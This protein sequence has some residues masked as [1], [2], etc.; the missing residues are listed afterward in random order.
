[1]GGRAWAWACH[2]L[3]GKARHA[4]LGG[5][6][7]AGLNT[8]LSAYSTGRCWAHALELL[9]RWPLE[10]A[11]ANVRSFGAA[12]AAC[13]QGGQWPWALELL[14]STRF[15]RVLP[16][17]FTFSSAMDACGKG[18]RWA[19]AQWL[20]QEMRLSCS[21]QADTIVFGAA[22]GACAAQQS[23][24]HRGLAL[25]QAAGRLGLE[26]SVVSW[27]AAV[28]ACEKDACWQQ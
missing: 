19:W 4:G 14:H 22:I 9:C 25:L 15:C 8:A 26:S 21:M 20:L 2:L 27:S 11:E 1:V 17:A 6:D 7:Q 3:F 23:L 12:I 24:W 18:L 13:A 16:N 5:P 28:G 10:E